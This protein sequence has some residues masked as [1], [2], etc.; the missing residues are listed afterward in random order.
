MPING[1]YLSEMPPEDWDCDEDEDGS[2]PS[3]K[4]AISNTNSS[5]LSK[6][7][8]A[9]SIEEDS[10]KFDETFDNEV[11]DAKRCLAEER[12][13]EH[14]ISLERQSNAELIRRID[15]YLKQVEEFEAASSSH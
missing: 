14:I 4:V 2:P 7:E 11:A 1:V 6:S 9:A 5:S 10:R 12:R 8:Q 15:E 3:K 13:K